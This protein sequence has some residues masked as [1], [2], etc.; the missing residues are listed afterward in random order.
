MPEKLKFRLSSMWLFVSVFTIVL[1]VFMPSYSSFNPASDAIGVATAAMF[2]L[3]F[4]SSLFGLAAMFF[5]HATLSLKLESMEGLYVNLLVMFALGLVQW[6][7]VVPRI[8]RNDPQIQTIEIPLDLQVPL[9]KPAIP[10]PAI[11]PYE[12]DD[13][14][15]VERIIMEDALLNKD[16]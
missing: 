12:T 15:P 4:P 14:T 7:W 10:T 2:I 5:V 9:F 3:S 16:R 13:R 1:P 8:W 6:F 11:P